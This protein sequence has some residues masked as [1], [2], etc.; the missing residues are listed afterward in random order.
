M[1]QQQQHYDIVDIDYNNEILRKEWAD[2][3]L[4]M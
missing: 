4:G 3:H 2:L 1:L